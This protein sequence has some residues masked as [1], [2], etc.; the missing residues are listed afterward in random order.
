MV[1]A[2]HSYEVK[3][4]YENLLKREIRKNYTNVLTESTVYLK[5]V[6]FFSFFLPNTI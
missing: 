4:S 1:I 5:N 3:Q 6:R 2:K